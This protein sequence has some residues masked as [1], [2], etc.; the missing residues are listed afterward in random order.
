[1]KNFVDT[2]ISN[3][4]I[5][6]IVFLLCCTVIC[7]EIYN[8]QSAK[9]I[10]S[11]HCNFS[12][13]KLPVE[14][15]AWSPDGQKIAVSR[16][17][18]THD[19]YYHEWI[20]IYKTPSGKFI[21]RT[22]RI[23]DFQPFDFEPVWTLQ[24]HDL[25]FSHGEQHKVSIVSLSFSSIVKRTTKTN[26]GMNMIFSR[27]GSWLDENHLLFSHRIVKTKKFQLFSLNLMTNKIEQIVFNQD[28]I[29][30]PTISPLMDKIAYIDLGNNQERILK[31]IL[32][33]KNV[34]LY[35]SSSKA[36]YDFAWSPD[37]LYLYYVLGNTNSNE[38]H[39]L[40]TVNFS[41]IIIGKA[42]CYV[43]PP[44][45][46]STSLL[47]ITGDNGEK[48]SHIF[49]FDLLTGKL[50]SS[51][52]ANTHYTNPCWSPDGSSLAYLMRRNNSS[53]HRICIEKLDN[54][55]NIKWPFQ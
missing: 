45:I 52:P 38:L 26:S 55:S 14:T 41:D 24:G 17:Q 47:A 25:L 5:I 19:Q 2:I 29:I 28:N 42:K 12:I 48:F 46:S 7:F 8:R 9:R 31:I 36:I 30:L 3:K 27:T 34:F 16:I 18:N 1:M 44:V 43:G 54:R 6:I 13:G 37:N 10:F 39:K 21:T 33:S 23:F 15:L 22:E 32:R 50:I 35:Q 4:L 11:N 51:S 40:N 49:I 53:E 20:E